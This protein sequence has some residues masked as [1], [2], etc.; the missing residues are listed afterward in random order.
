M[1][2]EVIVKRSPKDA[3]IHAQIGKTKLAFDA[4]GTAKA[5]VEPGTHVLIYFLVAEPGTEF[6]MEIKAPPEAAWSRPHR[7][8]SDGVTVGTKKFSVNA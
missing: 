4:T 7:I 6:T 2:K 5:Q 8:P 3:E 1:A